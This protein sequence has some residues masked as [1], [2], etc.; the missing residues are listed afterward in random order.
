MTLLELLIAMSIMVM[1]VGTLGALARGVQQSYEYADGHCQAAQH[2]RV[3]LDRIARTVREAAANEEFPGLLVVP[4]AGGPNE[5]P[6]ALVVWH[7]DGSPAN[8]DGRPLMSELVVF[9]PDDS[10]PNRL[11]ELSVPGD[12]RQAPAVDDSTGWRSEIDAMRLGGERIQ[13][14]DLL[15]TCSINNLPST[16]VRGAVRFQSRLRPSEDE[17]DDYR[18]GKLDFDELSWAQGLYGSRTGLRQVSL[19]IELQL[20][21]GK[22]HAAMEAE[23]YPAIPFFGSASLYYELRQ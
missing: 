14:T 7:P 1:V 22:D 15:R 17:W 13:L 4:D 6:E 2:A 21:P 8:P 9:C 3:V 16:A 23:A 10:Q 5:F 20:M 12:N 11:L 19:N 18:D